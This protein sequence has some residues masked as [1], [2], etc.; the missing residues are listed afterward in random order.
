[1]GNSFYQA[2]SSQWQMRREARRY[3]LVLLEEPN[4]HR[5]TRILIQARGQDLYRATLS[6]NRV[7][8]DSLVLSSVGSVIAYLRRQEFKNWNEVHSELANDEYRF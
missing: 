2:F 4:G 1:M 3:N 5:G 6:N 8:I 7:D